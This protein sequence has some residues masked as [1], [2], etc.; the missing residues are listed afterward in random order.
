MIRWFF[1]SEDATQMQKTID[2]LWSVGGGT[3]TL[4]PQVRKVHGVQLR[5]GVKFLFHQKV[6]VSDVK[7][8]VRVQS[9]LKDGQLISID[10]S[11]NRI[12]D[13]F[14]DKACTKDSGARIHA[15][16][17]TRAMQAFMTEHFIDR[18]AS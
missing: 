10:G 18:S 17:V 2:A 15:E 1:N 4:G 13:E 16:R 5:Q 12:V 7:V 9:E 14:S 3:I 11:G 6:T 8:P